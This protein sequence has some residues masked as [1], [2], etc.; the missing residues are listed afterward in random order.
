MREIFIPPLSL[1]GSAAIVDA[2][3]CYSASTIGDVY[4]VTGVCEDGYKP[5]DMGCC[6]RG[7]CNIFC[8]KCDDGCRG[9]KFK[10]RGQHHG[11]FPG[12]SEVDALCGVSQTED[13]CVTDKFK[14]LDTNH[15]G[16][17]SLAEFLAGIDIVRPGVT[18]SGLATAE[19][20]KLATELFDIYDTAKA[21]YLTLAEAETRHKLHF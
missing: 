9:S 1:L 8:C 2:K 20:D 7:S 5:G 6:G 19:L 21:G 4:S 11:S 17:V 12:L 15:D 16:K 14:E 18:L 3:C 13:Q 10:A